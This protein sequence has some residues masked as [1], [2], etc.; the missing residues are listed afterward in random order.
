MLLHAPLASRPRVPAPDF[1]PARNGRNSRKI[2]IQYG[3]LLLVCAVLS[4][5]AADGRSCMAFRP[6]TFPHERDF[7]P[8]STCT[9]SQINRPAWPLGWQTGALH[10]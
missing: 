6:H 10:L 7:R 9:P 1:I 8:A 5:V 4:H 2:A 3:G